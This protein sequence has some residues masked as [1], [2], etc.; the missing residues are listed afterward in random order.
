[1]VRYESD[2]GVTGGQVGLL[3]WSASSGGGSGS[4]SLEHRVVICM[5]CKVGIRPGDGVQL[6]FW[7]IHRLKG[8]VMRQILDYS[9]TAE[10]IANPQAVPVPADGSPFVQQLPIVDGLSC[11]D[12]RFLTTSRKLIRVHRS[13]SGHDSTWKEVRLQSLSRG[14]RARYSVVE[15]VQGSIG[16]DGTTSLRSTA[17]GSPQRLLADCLARYEESLAAE[18]EETRRIEIAGQ[19][20]TSSQ[21]GFARWAGRDT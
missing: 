21:P 15:Q 19:D 9:Y 2:G 12:C 10:P 7:R 11:S 18:L 16:P 3:S 4:G 17:S 5:S 6:H 8:E 1:A 20:Q 13:Q 14:S